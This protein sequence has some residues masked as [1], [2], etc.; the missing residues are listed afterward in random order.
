MNNKH[1]AGISNYVSRCHRSSVALAFHSFSFH[2]CVSDTGCCLDK[3]TLTFGAIHKRE[4]QA[5]LGNALPWKDLCAHQDMKQAEVICLSQKAWLPSLA[6]PYYCFCFALFD[7]VFP[8][9]ALLSFI[10]SI[11]QWPVPGQEQPS[12]FRPPLPK[13]NPSSSK[14]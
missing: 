1:L 14:S 7:F 12:V 3:V 2:V 11:S 6:Q 10:C 8:H 13:F 5:G 9:L 4:R